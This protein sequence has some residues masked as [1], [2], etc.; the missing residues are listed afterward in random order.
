MLVWSKYKQLQ[1]YTLGSNF[2]V[3]KVLQWERKRFSQLLFVFVFYKR[4]ATI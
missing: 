2:K 4:L 1:G 3:G